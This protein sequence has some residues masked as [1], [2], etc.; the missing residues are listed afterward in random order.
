[1]QLEYRESLERKRK[2]TNKKTCIQIP[3]PTKQKQL[4]VNIIPGYKHIRDTMCKPFPYPKNK[5]LLISFSTFL[6]KPCLLFN[7]SAYTFLQTIDI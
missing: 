6:R 7:F 3:L 2:K 4:T 1:M 5:N